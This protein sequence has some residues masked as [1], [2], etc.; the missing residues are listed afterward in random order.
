MA[1]IH[2][3]NLIILNHKI[4]FYLSPEVVK[5]PLLRFLLKYK[6]IILS[7]R[8]NDFYLFLNFRVGMLVGAEEAG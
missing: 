8:K 4:G 5:N 1:K 6:G 3:R 7:K 2:F